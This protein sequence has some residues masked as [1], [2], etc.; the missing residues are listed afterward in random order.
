MGRPI[1][2]PAIIDGVEWTVRDSGELRRAFV[3][4][5]NKTVVVPM[6]G[7]PVADMIRNHEMAHVAITPRDIPLF[8]KLAKEFPNR[9]LQCAEDARVY[10]A[11]KKAGIDTEQAHWPDKDIAAMASL[12]PSPKNEEERTRCLV[13]T[14]GTGDFPRLAAAMPKEN[15]E[16]AQRL[17][18]KHYGSYVSRGELPPFESAIALGR[19]LHEIY[20]SEEEEGIGTASAGESSGKST[21][22]DKSEI[23]AKDRIAPSRPFTPGDQDNAESVEQTVSKDDF[24]KA[25]R[26]EIKETLGD[27]IMDYVHGS[28][29]KDAGPIADENFRIETPK[30]RQPHKGKSR[31]GRK[32]VSA[33]TGSVPRR[34]NRYAVDGAVFSRTIKRGF[35][36]I[37]VDCSGSMNF[38]MEDVDEIVNA[39]PNS[40]IAVYSG[41]SSTGTL[42][43][44]AKEGKRIEEIPEFH[45]G[46]VV[47]WQSLNWLKKQR[48]PRYWICDGI[49]T[50]QSDGVL[51]IAYCHKIARLCKLN[52]IKRFGS[53][54]E[55]LKGKAKRTST[56]EEEGW[57][58]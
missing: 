35:G 21:D 39:L 27:Q 40:I 56:V 45:G 3:D 34:L 25:E 29:K 11:L 37:L 9:N 52:G 51:G 57:E 15:V 54:E 14:I 7:G 6:E 20:A 46:N 10:V 44:V 23:I 17:W 30:L 31:T 42:V 47:D 22:S 38:S 28:W 26:K 33:D 43:V 53:L 24:T 8:M 41:R 13:A 50:G 32:Q 4:F 1:P 2:A 58:R 18:E 12:P 36:T 55:L 19:E 16:E 49:V 5:D 48:G